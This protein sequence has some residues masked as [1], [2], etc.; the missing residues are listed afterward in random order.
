[1]CLEVLFF[2]NGAVGGEGTGVYCVA[3][4]FIVIILSLC[5]KL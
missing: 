3:L 4:S 2:E 5:M 1:V